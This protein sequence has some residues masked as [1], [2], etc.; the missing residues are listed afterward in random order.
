MVYCQLHSRSRQ[1]QSPPRNYARRSDVL[2]TIKL[3]PAGRLV[4][5]AV[6]AGPLNGARWKCVQKAVTIVGGLDP[7]VQD[8]YR[9][10]VH[11]VADQPPES[12][13]EPQ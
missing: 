9:A 8:N 5:H 10:P 13:A 12:L 4:A 11:L 1:L 6:D 7:P 3:Q 2:G